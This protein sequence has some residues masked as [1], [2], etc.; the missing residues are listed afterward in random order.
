MARVV[1][2]YG[3]WDNDTSLG[4]WFDK[5]VFAAFD[6]E[7]EPDLMKVK[8]SY[9]RMFKVLDVGGMLELDAVAHEQACAAAGSDAAPG[10]LRAV[11]KY[12]GTKGAP[13]I[14]KPPA[15]PSA[16]GVS[17]SC[18]SS[19]EA[20]ELQTPKFGNAGAGQA[21]NAKNFPEALRVRS[22]TIAQTVKLPAEVIARLKGLA[23]PYDRGKPAPQSVVMVAIRRVTQWLINEFGV[24]PVRFAFRYLFPTTHFAH[25]HIVRAA[26]RL[27]LCRTSYP[28]SLD[29][30]R[31]SFP[32]N[33]P[34]LSIATTC[35]SSNT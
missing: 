8:M 5:T 31:R 16:D 17:P 34:I 33:V 28:M 26:L 2:E 19:A 27:P 21:K 18:P 12:L 11:C 1:P 6:E 25:T 20:A 32:L 4:D 29:L 24:S 35:P 7:D 22:M 14:P 13:F 15:R 9:K 30:W 23:R 10:I 3:P